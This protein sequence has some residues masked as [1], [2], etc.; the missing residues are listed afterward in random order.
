MLTWF[1]RMLTWFNGNG[2]FNLSLR[3]ILLDIGTPTYD[4][5]KFL[6]PILK[7]LTEND[8]TVH[9]SFSFASEVCKFNSKN[10][11]ASLDAEIQFTN[12]PLEETIDN[13]INDLF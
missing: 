6:V 2:W 3:P 7:P 1:N 8:Y 5:A 13:L 11:M 4:L 9:D 10:L 12:I